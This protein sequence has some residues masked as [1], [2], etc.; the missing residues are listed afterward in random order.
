MVDTLVLWLT[1]YHSLVKRALAATTA[2]SYAV[3]NVSIIYTYIWTR[4][5]FALEQNN[6]IGIDFVFERN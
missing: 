4:N 1:V 2:N 5:G 6:W 3:D